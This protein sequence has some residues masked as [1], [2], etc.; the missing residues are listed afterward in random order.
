MVKMEAASLFEMCGVYLD[1]AIFGGGDGHP[2]IELK[3]GGHDKTLVVIRM[4]ADQVDAS[5]RA[6]EAA[7]LAIQAAEF[8]AQIGGCAGGLCCRRN[9][10]VHL[11]SEAT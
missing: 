3:G 9:D 11:R 10:T 1:G 5:G 6:I 7:A 8:I 4:L 2:A